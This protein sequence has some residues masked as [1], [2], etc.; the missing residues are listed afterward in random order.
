MICWCA[1]GGWPLGRHG[2]P[3]SPDLGGCS[4]WPRERCQAPLPAAYQGLGDE[5]EDGRRY[6]A[7]RHVAQHHLVVRVEL[8]GRRMRVVAALGHRERDDP[9]GG[10]GQPLDDGRWVVRREQVVDERADDPV[11]DRA[12]GVLLDEGVQAV[13]RGEHLLHAAVVRQHA[14]A[15]DAPS[16]RRAGGQQPV[17]V[18]RLMGTVEPADTEVHDARGDRVAVVAGDRHGVG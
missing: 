1:P 9:R 10:R 5:A 17:E 7:R 3:G 8:T 14:D 18:H 4:G 2:C 15:A 12:V 16:A 13:L 11:P 6:R